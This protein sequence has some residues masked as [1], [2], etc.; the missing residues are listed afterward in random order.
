M[1][2]EQ[3]YGDQVTFI[4]LPSLADL[5]DIDEFIAET[6]TSHIQQLPDIEGEVWR[7]FGVTR[8]RTYVYINDDGTW[9]QSGYG[10]LQE[11]VEGL[12]NS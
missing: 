7:Q 1:E 11:D 12:I 6:G 8:Q 3:K 9:R 2:V 10:S 5:D 4:G